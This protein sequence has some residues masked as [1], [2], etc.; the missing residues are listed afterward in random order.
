MRV[1]KVKLFWFLASDEKNQKRGECN[2]VLIFVRQYGPRLSPSSVATT[3]CRTRWC[4]VSHV[5]SRAVDYL[6]HLG[7]V[8]LDFFQ[9][10]PALRSGWVE[11]KVTLE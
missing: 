4:D 5:T 3:W 9:H 7:V 10:A 8:R 2:C 6:Q 11:I 1:Y